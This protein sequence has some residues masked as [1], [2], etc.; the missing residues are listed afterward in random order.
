M[1]LE[2][3]IAD[4][5]SDDG[6]REILTQYDDASRVIENHAKIASTGLNAAIR[7]A[8]GEVTFEWTLTPSMLPTIS[9]L[10]PAT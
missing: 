1:E 9:K 7:A 6:T 5:I 3:L 4:G 8:K 10:R 2:I